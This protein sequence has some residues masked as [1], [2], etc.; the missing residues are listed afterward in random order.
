M[1]KLN[2]FA[3]FGIMF[4]SSVLLGSGLYSNS[5]PIYA[6]ENEA[7]VEVDI[8]QQN[9]CKKDTECENENEINNSLTITTTQGQEEEQPETPTCEDCFIDNL[10][11]GEIIQ[12]EIA[13]G[14]ATGG[15]ISSIEDLCIFAQV[16]IGNNG[17]L[18]V[19]SE[20]LYNEGLG[21]GIPFEKL[22]T[23]EECLDEFFGVDFPTPG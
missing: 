20:L 11:V 4:L 18:V 7:E 14:D 19:I 9:K 8:E 15:D 5:V 23:I 1:S 6:Q 3:I 22:K 12:F 13:L 17:D 16:V 10:D 21:V 2:V